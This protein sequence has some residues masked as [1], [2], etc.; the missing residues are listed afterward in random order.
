[1]QSYPKLN[2]RHL[3]VRIAQ[4]KNEHTKILCEDLVDLKVRSERKEGDP[5]ELKGRILKIEEK[6]EEFDISVDTFIQEVQ[7]LYSQLK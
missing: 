4:W 7:I 1:M 6:L 3:I 2:L 5:E